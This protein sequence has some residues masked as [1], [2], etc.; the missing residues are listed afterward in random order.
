MTNKKRAIYSG[1]FDPITNGHI[2]IIKR[3]LNVFDEVIVAIANSSAKKPMFTIDQRV[4]LVNIATKELNGV[5]AVPF[6][7]L[8]VDFAKQN[9]ITNI[10]RGLRAVSDFEYELQMGYANSSLDKNI[11]TMYFMPTLENAFVS[12]SIVRELIKFNGSYQH[13]I[14]KQIEQEIIK[15]I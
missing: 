4:D 5:S 3:A 15:C 9:N 6:S 2:D 8:L 10:I 13:L 1:T 12:S 7:C 11:D 14:P